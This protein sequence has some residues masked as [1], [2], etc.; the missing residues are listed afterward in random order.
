[1]TYGTAAFGTDEYGSGSVTSSS[2]IAVP[3]DTA[4]L[5][6]I[7]NAITT[8]G[9]TYVVELEN[10]ILNFSPQ[11]PTAVGGTRVDSELILTGK[12]AIEIDPSQVTRTIN[13]M[14]IMNGVSSMD[15]DNDLVNLNKA[16][17]WW[18][19]FWPFRRDLRIVAPPSG[20]EIGSPVEVN[21]DFLASVQGK[22]RRDLQDIYA[23]E[24]ISVNPEIWNPLPTHAERSAS[25]ILVRF[26]L[27]K[28]LN[29]NEEALKTYYVYYGNKEVTDRPPYEVHSY[30][31]FPVEVDYSSDG[32]SY[33]RPGEDWSD[34]LTR[35]TNAKATF[36]FWGDQ[37]R[38][39]ADMGPEFGIVEIQIDNEESVLFD[40]YSQ[41]SQSDVLIF[42]QYNLS[43]GPHVLRI[44]ATGEKHGSSSSANV[45]IK[46]IHYRKH[47]IAENIKEES[48]NKLLWSSAIGGAI[49][50]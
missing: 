21:L 17:P 20:L 38:Y 4:I 18:S 15:L 46:S 32:I 5:E 16:E 27:T 47:A 33:T 35:K 37:I 6:Y 43:P 12:A 28:A 45:N 23:V 36:N 2:A 41:L 44:K 40:L 11:E 19:N 10:A 26:N 30:N 42:E 9:G 29:E 49:N 22:I 3:V 34:G 24:L 25:G 13:I 50:G 1:M 31:P 14:P 7:P 39:Y 8:T 48:N